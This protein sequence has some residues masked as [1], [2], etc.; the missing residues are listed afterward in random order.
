MGP[1]FF[2]M[3]S[4]H[5]SVRFQ[6][7]YQIPKFPRSDSHRF[8]LGV[9]LAASSQ[10]H[11]SMRLYPSVMPFLDA[12]SHLYKRV[13]PSVGRSVRRSVCHAF[14][15]N[16]WNWEFYIQK[17][18]RRHTKSWITSKQLSSISTTKGGYCRTQIR[19]YAPKFLRTHRWPLG[20][21]LKILTDVNFLHSWYSTHG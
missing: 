16:A 2:K 20:L 15:K 7:F 21:V 9:V 17:W 18:S 13:C 4:V 8:D 1:A 11:Q 19:G 12:S 6:R 14:V 5:P 10:L 3:L